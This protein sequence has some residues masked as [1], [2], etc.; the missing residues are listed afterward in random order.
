MAHNHHMNDEVEHANIRRGVL[1]VVV[2]GAL[3][4]G[5]DYGYRLGRRLRGIHELCCPENELYTCLKG[6]EKKGLVS[7][8]WG[9]STS[10]PP[11]KYYS[12]TSEGG[13]FLEST[14]RVCRS[15]AAALM[16]PLVCS[17]CGAAVTEAQT[18]GSGGGLTVEIHAGLTW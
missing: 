10:G 18:S 16:R 15:L 9:S 6:L 5:P 3:Q 11:R 12:L 13:L 4:N 2:L 17:R 8:A 1:R 14:R 7:H